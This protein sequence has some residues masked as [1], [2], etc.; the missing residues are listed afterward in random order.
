[1]SHSAMLAGKGGATVS[2]SIEKPRN[3]AIDTSLLK[4]AALY[5]LLQRYI[6][7]MEEQD[8]HGFPRPD[9]A[10]KGKALVNSANKFRQNKST[11]SLNLASD[12]RLCDR[13]SV[14]YK[15]NSKGMAVKE[16]VDFIF[17]F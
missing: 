7:T 11:A 9:P 8:F 3:S 2:W 14:V 1:M 5:K 6:L 16:Y 17:A 13:C 10:V 15:V 4:G 12:E